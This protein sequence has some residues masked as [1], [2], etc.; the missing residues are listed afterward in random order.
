MTG[1]STST[2]DE[3]TLRERRRTTVVL[4]LLAAMT[5]GS[6][7]F[8][9]LTAPG[10]AAGNTPTPT[11]TAAPSTPTPALDDVAPYYAENDTTVDNESF[12]E[13]RR[14]ASLENTTNFLTRIGPVV[15]GSGT[16]QG[17]V[18]DAGILVT[19]LLV[20]GLLLA[21]IDVITHSEGNAFE[22]NLA[23]LALEESLH[24]MAQNCL[25]VGLIVR[26]VAGYR[27]HG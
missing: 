24:E 11:P 21:D 10:I 2:T 14:N 18:G 7:C 4:V 3:E 27:W 17:G 9:L 25:F 19:G 16:A 13:G 6:V 5:V 20:G 23:T 8:G 26:V 15:V 22:G 12:F 1:N